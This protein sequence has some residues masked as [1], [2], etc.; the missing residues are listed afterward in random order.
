[1]S[2]FVSQI[3]W[4]LADTNPTGSHRTFISSK[5]KWILYVERSE[6]HSCKFFYCWKGLAY[7]FLVFSSMQDQPSGNFGY[8][9][10]GLMY[11]LE[12]CQMPWHA[13]DCRGRA[14]FWLLWVAVR[15][16]CLVHRHDLKLRVATSNIHEWCLQLCAV[17]SSQDRC[18]RWQ[19]YWRSTWCWPGSSHR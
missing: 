14:V 4:N 1:M 3:Q 11:L 5:N 9:K 16:S 7:V 6:M 15:Y 18:P 10:I 12:H 8:F 19:I 2:A 17:H 13:S